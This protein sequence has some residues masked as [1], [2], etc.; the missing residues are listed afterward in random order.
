MQKVVGDDFVRK[1]VIIMKD[2]IRAPQKKNPDIVRHVAD[3]F[4]QIVASGDPVEDQVAP[5][6]VT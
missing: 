1:L 4:G 2:V 6:A 5:P 3:A